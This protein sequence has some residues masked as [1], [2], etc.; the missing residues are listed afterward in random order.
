[1]YYILSSKLIFYY[2]VLYF[3]SQNFNF[4]ILEI[5]LTQKTKMQAPP[6][7]MQILASRHQISLG[8]PDAAQRAAMRDEWMSVLEFSIAAPHPF[9]YT[10]IAE[11]Y[12]ELLSLIVSVRS[13]IMAQTSTSE[14]RRDA[15]YTLLGSYCFAFPDYP[16]PRTIDELNRFVRFA[17]LA[18]GQFPG[19]IDAPTIFYKIKRQFATALCALFLGLYAIS[20]DRHDDQECVMAFMKKYK[21]TKL[22]IERIYDYN[23]LSDGGRITRVLRPEQLSSVI[24]CYKKLWEITGEAFAC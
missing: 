24:G 16:P 4:F 5:R 21:I 2:G 11:Y 20:N 22:A 19:E 10:V 17:Q 12:K 9:N 3:V 13:V 8:N 7:F 23:A 14:Q 18:L 15:V 1:V 6:T